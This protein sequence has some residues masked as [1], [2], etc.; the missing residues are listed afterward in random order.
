MNNEKST[1]STGKYTIELTNGP[2]VVYKIDELGNKQWVCS[3]SD[4]ALA[5][6]IVE[7]LVLVEHKRFYYPESQP[8]ITPT[9]SPKIK[10]P[11]LKRVE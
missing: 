11:F 9:K 10:P 8:Q 5:M 6:D 4:P 3:A 7:G 1:L 2:S